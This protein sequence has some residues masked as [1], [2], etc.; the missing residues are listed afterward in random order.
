M[1]EIRP[2][3]TPPAPA[4]AFSDPPKTPNQPLLALFGS[5]TGAPNGK[6]KEGFVWEETKGIE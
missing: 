4:A 1:A 5:A 3:P 6:P 2:K